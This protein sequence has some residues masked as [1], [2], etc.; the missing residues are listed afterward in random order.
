MKKINHHQIKNIQSLSTLLDQILQTLA[1]TDLR[2]TLKHI[3]YDTQISEQTFEIL[4]SLNENPD[5][6]DEFKTDDFYVVL[7]SVL[8][9][10]PTLKIWVDE[11]TD[12]QSKDIS[13][14]LEI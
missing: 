7:S 6:I 14:F 8:F 12:L 2:V 1:S 4:R 13:F 3:A 11:K 10:Y 9:R 5:L